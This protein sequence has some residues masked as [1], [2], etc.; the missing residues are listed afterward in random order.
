MADGGTIDLNKLKQVVDV[1]TILDKRKL[2]AV[3]KTLETSLSGENISKYFKGTDTLL[4]DLQEA[5][6]KFNRSM[7]DTDAKNL[8]NINN[9]LKALKVD[10]ASLVPNFEEIGNVIEK[11]EQKSKGLRGIIKVQDFKDV[12]VA[13]NQFKEYGLD[14]EEIFGKLGAKGNFSELSKQLEQ[15]AQTIERYRNKVSALRDELRNAENASGVSDL[16]ENKKNI[17]Q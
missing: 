8:V 13:L 6:K 2:N 14:I 1:E 7:S 4:D 12:F 10:T 5:Y 9:I 11:A 3:L 17:G 16:I 15:Q